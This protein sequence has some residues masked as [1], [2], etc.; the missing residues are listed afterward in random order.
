MRTFLGLAV[1]NL[2]RNRWRSALPAVA[3]TVGV[4]LVV[5]LQAFIDGFVRSLV[6]DAVQARMGAI[7]VHKK[8]YLDAQQDVLT[9]DLPDDPAVVARLRAVP[10]V[11]A[12]T[13]RIDFDGMVSNGAVSTMFVA[14]AIDPASEYD[15]CPLRRTEVA[16][17]SPPLGVE[18]PGG[19]LMDGA[20]VE[21]LG[22]GIGTTVIVSSAT[23]AGAA[24]AL[25]VTVVGLLPEKD[26]THRRSAVVPLALA[27][28]LLG[29]PGRVTQYVLDVADLE[30]VEDVAA[31]VRVTLGADHEVRTWRDVR[32]IVDTTERVGGVMF[33]IVFILSLLV[34]SGIVN[35]VLMSVQERIREIGTMMAMGLRRRGVLLLFLLES[36][37]LG[38]L[39]AGAGAVVGLGLVQVWADG[40]R[41]PA[42]NITG[43][44]VVVPRADVALVG[45]AILL[46]CLVAML[47]A[48][49][50]AWKA[51]RLNP[52][53]ALR[54]V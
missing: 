47:A 52:V 48:L 10:G 46:A 22:G 25:D 32:A 6:Q 21:S 29:M 51:S 39:S 27:Q 18:H 17:G 4:A 16:A 8:G 28:T 37:V 50:P 45:G 43:V 54:S 5:F 42:T 14:T 26:P 24:N 40:I 12:V 19:V 38:L 7:Q 44:M 31:R 15:V 53:D 20:L 11:K 36:T 35:T 30:T 13:R 9:L 33:F 41:F 3:L 49:Y 2:L 23:Q 34:V 1:R